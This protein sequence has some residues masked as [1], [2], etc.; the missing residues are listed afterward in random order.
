MVI[1]IINIAVASLHCLKKRYQT[2]VV[3]TTFLIIN[4][5]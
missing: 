4:C 1:V 5:D 2:G 3:M